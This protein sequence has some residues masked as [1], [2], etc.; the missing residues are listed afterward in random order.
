M[1]EEIH[2]KLKRNPSQVLFGKLIVLLAFGI[3]CGILMA[4]SDEKEY[5]E[6]KALTK[7]EYINNYETYKA[8]LIGKA[9]VPVAVGV[10]IF[11]L[12]TFT[13]FGI[14][15]GLGILSG[16]LIGVIAELVNGGNADTRF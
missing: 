13:F 15:E 5:E 1:E 2:I 7:E 12:M 3:C 10:V 14:Y 8:G 9:P 11:V 16:K 6:G 4:I